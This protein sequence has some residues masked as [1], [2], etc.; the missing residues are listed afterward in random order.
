[1][2]ITIEASGEVEKKYNGSTTTKVGK[3]KKKLISTEHPDNEKFWK[4]QE[5]AFFKMKK[6][7]SA[8]IEGLSQHASEESVD[9]KTVYTKIPPRTAKEKLL[10]TCKKRYAETYDTTTK[11]KEKLWDS[12]LCKVNKKIR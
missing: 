10:K 2:P 1:M 4:I 6:T 7:G 9:F 3:K 12:A 11:D 8:D 5:E